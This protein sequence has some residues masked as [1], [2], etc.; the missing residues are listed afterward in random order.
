MTMQAMKSIKAY[1]TKRGFN[2]VEL[3][4]Y[5]KFELDQAALADMEIELNAS[6]INEHVP[7]IES[8]NRTMKERVRC[9]YR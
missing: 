9:M 1:Y 6:V 8:L 4:T 5:Q 2:I 3:R 7:Y